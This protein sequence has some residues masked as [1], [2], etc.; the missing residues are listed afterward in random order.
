MEQQQGHRQLVVTRV[1]GTLCGI[2]IGQV[3]EIIPVPAITPV[4]K[5]AVNLLGVIDVRGAVIAVVCLRACLG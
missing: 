2:D 3:H 1:G 4:P 5:S